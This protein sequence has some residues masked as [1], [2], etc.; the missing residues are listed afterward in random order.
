MQRIRTLSS[1]MIVLVWL[2]VCS[3]AVYVYGGGDAEYSTIG[4]G[5]TS[6]NYS[7][8]IRVAPRMFSAPDMPALCATVEKPAKL[9]ARENHIQIRVG[10]L[11]SFGDLNIVAVDSTGQLLKP[12]PIIV[13][14][15]ADINKTIDITNYRETSGRI[16]ALRSGSFQIW[17]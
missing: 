1:F 3:H 16:L 4:E 5:Y 12:I 6:I 9:I 15:D 17:I 14:T 7:E 13:D 8:G 10:E 11:F 2:L